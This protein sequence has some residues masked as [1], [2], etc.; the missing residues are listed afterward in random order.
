MLDDYDNKFIP[1]VLP[2]IIII[3]WYLITCVLN[4]FSAYIL[5]SPVDVVNS[6]WIVIQ[7][8]KLLTNTVN[9]L[10]KVFTFI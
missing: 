7:N 3:I 9:T 5:P 10:F 1:W 8:G 4:L 6:A 2:I